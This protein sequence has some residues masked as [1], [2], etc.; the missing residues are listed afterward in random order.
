MKQSLKREIA[1]SMDAIHFSP[2]GKD[3]MVNNLLAHL[4]AQQQ[5]TQRY[6][7]RK[8][9]LVALAATLLLATLTGAAVFTRWSKSMNA[10]YDATQEQREQAEE[11]GLSAMPETSSGTENV[12]SVTDQ[13]VTI[14]AAQTIV[15]KYSA[16]VTFRIKG[17]ELPEGETP[18]LTVF[19]V[20]VKDAHTVV[21]P[22][23]FYNGITKNQTGEQ[24]YTDGSPLLYDASGSPI[25]DYTAADGSLE[26]YTVFS[27]PSGNN[28]VG[29]EIEIQI[30][31][32]GTEEKPGLL[33][34]EWTLKWTLNGTADTLITKPYT[35][36]GETG[37]TLLEV[38]ISPI[39]VCGL[40]LIDNTERQITEDQYVSNYE[41]EG[42]APSVPHHLVRSLFVGYRTKDGILHTGLSKSTGVTTITYDAGTN[43]A[44]PDFE[45]NDNDIL[46]RDQ[47]LVKTILDPEDV[48]ALLFLKS[49]PEE[50]E[51]SELTEE[52]FYI[53]PIR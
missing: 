10:Y 33:R 13:G 38:E 11:I 27:F 37:I 4:E 49:N 6:G 20:D 43:K 45:M 46:V 34:G 35:A 47:N 41:G 12:I 39:S 21:A 3:A 22:G 17:F 30:T 32:I 26:Y 16:M 7:K 23:Y 36:I 18:S 14:T 15:D 5:N 53:L 19:S 52:N 48:D 8:L 42:V 40:F 2:E 25:P 51:L 29:K 24:V 9:I 28:P 44:Y 50:K 31:A 1:E